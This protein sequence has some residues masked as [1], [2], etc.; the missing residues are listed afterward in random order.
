MSTITNLFNFYCLVM[1]G[2]KGTRFWPESTEKRPKQYLNLISSK[3]LLEETFER[4]DQFIDKEKRFVVT[5]K[6]QEA[7]CLESS[8]NQI[9]KNGMIFEPSGRNTGPCILM[10]LA[11]LLSKGVSEKDIIAIVPA[12]HVILNRAGFQE[13]LKKAAYFSHQKQNIVTIGITPHFPHTGFGY[14]EK[15]ELVEG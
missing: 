13:T 2:G 7:L 9:A 6:E 1:A 15:G 12:D 4:F 10:S 3:T 14:I 8:K 11:S 5:V